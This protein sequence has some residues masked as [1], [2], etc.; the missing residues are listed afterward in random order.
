MHNQL[1]A[2]AQTLF[3][4]SFHQNDKKPAFYLPNTQ[5]DTPIMCLLSLVSLMKIYSREK[6]PTLSLRTNMQN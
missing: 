2:M 6:A 1:L 5:L 4:T 3:L